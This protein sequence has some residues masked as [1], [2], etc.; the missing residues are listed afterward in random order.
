MESLN[1]DCRTVMFIRDILVSAFMMNDL[2]LIIL[3]QIDEV[4]NKEY[5]YCRIACYCRL[6]CSSV[7]EIFRYTSIHISSETTSRN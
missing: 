6:F 3:W 1:T 2:R 7:G 4:R 5:I